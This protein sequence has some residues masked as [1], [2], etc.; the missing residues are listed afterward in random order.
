MPCSSRNPKSSAR[1]EAGSPLEV[2]DDQT[3]S[4]TYADDLAVAVTELAGRLDGLGGVYHVVNRGAVT[5]FEVAREIARALGKPDHPVTAISSA[6][7]GRPAP[8]PA[9]SAL[10]PSKVEAA[11]GRP[12][13]A[14]NE[15]L[16]A[17]LRSSPPTKAGAP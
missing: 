6:T 1:G 4:P 13:R 3:A 12:M 2:V 8:R 17:F 16:G 14:W 15:A 9:Y 10:D 5:W 11:L 7:L